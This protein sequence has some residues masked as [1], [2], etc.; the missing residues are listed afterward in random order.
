MHLRHLTRAAPLQFVTF[1]VLASAWSA[2]LAA[3]T[4]LSAQ[5]TYSFKSANG[6]T[7]TL[8]M[9]SDISGQSGNANSTD[10]SA[11]LTSVSGKPAVPTLDLAGQLGWQ[12]GS[13]FNSASGT[14]YANGASAAAFT[15][16]ALADKKQNNTAGSFAVLFDTTGDG[17]LGSND[18]GLALNATFSVQSNTITITQGS[19]VAFTL[20]AASGT[21]VPTSAFT[22]GSVTAL[23]NYTASINGSVN[24]SITDGNT[25]SVVMA[26]LVS[27]ISGG[28]HPDL[29]KPTLTTAFTSGQISAPGSVNLIDWYGPSGTA[30]QTANLNIPEPATWAWSIGMMGPGAFLLLRRRRRNAASADRALAQRVA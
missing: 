16:T 10:I 28:W 12:S 27:D 30:V 26:A 11:V 25:Y 14:Y 4:L 8:V 7:P 18:S 2:P 6:G 1:G 29:G 9:T 15:F 3:Q 23:G 21:F 5:T 17:T 20:G 24:S 13:F 19:L 22:V